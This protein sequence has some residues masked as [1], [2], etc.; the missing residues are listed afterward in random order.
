MTYLGAAARGKR[1]LKRFRGQSTR[2]MRQRE[3]KNK[4]NFKLWLKGR[5]FE[6]GL[7]ILSVIERHYIEQESS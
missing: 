2:R 3:Q 7:A 5:W 4:N 6:I 1:C